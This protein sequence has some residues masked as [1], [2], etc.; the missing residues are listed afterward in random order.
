M[1]F[2][3][4]LSL[5]NNQKSGLFSENIPE[6]SPVLIPFFEAA[7]ALCMADPDHD[8]PKQAQDQNPRS[9][10]GPEFEA[11]MVFFVQI[12]LNCRV[13]GSGHYRSVL[14]GFPGTK[15]EQTEP[16]TG[17]F[18]PWGSSTPDRF[19]GICCQTISSVSSPHQGMKVSAQSTDPC[20]L[21]IENFEGARQRE[22][23]FTILPCIGCTK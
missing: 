7:N 20:F 23:N 22:K 11:N 4:S 8:R 16:E 18:Y 19:P 14:R 5:Q 21:E 17:L 9:F 3:T 15:K 6:Y 10:Q 13:S 1:S 12:T 2:I